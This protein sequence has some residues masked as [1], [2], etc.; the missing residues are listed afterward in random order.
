MSRIQVLRSAVV[1]NLSS[2]DLLLA[3]SLL[4]YE[5]FDWV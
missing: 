1:M 4:K 5:R 3:P 2:F